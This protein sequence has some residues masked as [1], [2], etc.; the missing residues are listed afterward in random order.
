MGPHKG[1]GAA[2]RAGAQ[3]GR[4]ARRTIAANYSE[5]LGVNWRLATDISDAAPDHPVPANRAYD[6]ELY[7]WVAG[8]IGLTSQDYSASSKHDLQMAV[9][10]RLA[11]SLNARMNCDDP[12]FCTT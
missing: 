1:A 4:D 11:R 9:A 2:I 3:R 5:A 12:E 6:P 7:V 10:I 8:L